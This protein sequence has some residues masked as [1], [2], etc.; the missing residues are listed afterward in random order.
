MTPTMTPTA[1]PW[2]VTCTGHELDLLN[3]APGAITGP[4]LAH[5]L[6]QL[7]RFTGHALRPYSV[8]EHSL[9][10]VEICEREFG[11]NP[12]TLR[13]TNG[14][15][16][17]LLHDAHEAYSGDLN[18]PAK[19]IVGPAWAAF[20]HRLEHAVRA[21]FAVR[22]ASFDHAALIK[23][24]D[25]IALATERR[26][27]LPASP[28][29]W[30]MLADVQPLSWCRLDTPERA[31]MPWSDWRDRW[32]DQLQALDWRRNELAGLAGGTPGGT[33]CAA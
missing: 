8:A 28:T 32:L 2:I 20:E 14:L 33:P 9:L 6:A 25:L 11:L 15:L 5:A 12:A 22:V 7:N 10:V 13:G 31:A 17:A 23:R 4:G 27:L 3:P 26:D 16:A 18:T 30:P 19:G 21:A 24:A 1:A 29:P